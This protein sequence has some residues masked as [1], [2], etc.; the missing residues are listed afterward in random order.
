MNTTI[1]PTNKDF[2]ERKW[3]LI[4]AKDKVLGR[5]ST[6]IADL[7]RGKGKVNY[8]P[9]LNSGDTVVVINAKYIRLTGKKLEQ[10]EYYTHSGYRGNLKTQT[11]KEKL[12]KKPEDV[13]YLAVRGMLPRT[14]LRNDQ[15]K[16]LKIFPEEKHNHEAQ[17]PIKLDL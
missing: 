1:F 13:I 2:Q 17:Q 5:L 9:H 4:D 16:N 6:K 7:L 10:K 8:T 12:K 14:R 15:L 11:A 3:Y